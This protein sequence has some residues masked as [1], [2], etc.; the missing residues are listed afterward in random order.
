MEAAFLD[1]D[2]DLVP[3]PR[4]RSNTWPRVSAPPT[5]SPPPPTPD[6]VAQA[7]AVDGWEAA[8]TLAVITEDVVDAAGPGLL[9]PS[10]P[11][12][13]SRAGAVPPPLPPRPRNP[14]GSESYADLIAQVRVAAPARRL[15][16]LRSRCIPI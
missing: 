6:G 4:S 3:Q 9:P 8:A 10:A 15:S 1:L 11:H 2:D 12:A 13:S 14:W 16:V 5:T 7:Q